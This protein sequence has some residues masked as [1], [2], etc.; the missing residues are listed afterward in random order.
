MRNGKAR[1]FF[2][3]EHG[4][5]HVH[6]RI[7]E[8]GNEDLPARVVFRLCRIPAADAD[9]D[10]VLH[11]DVALFKLS[12]KYIENAAASDDKVA[13]RALHGAVNQLFHIPDYNRKRPATQAADRIKYEFFREDRLYKA[14]SCM[15]F[16]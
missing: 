14:I 11:R 7:D 15:T 16:I 2:G 10:A 8:S 4:A 12:R 9:D 13:F 6:M 5:L 3:R 1:K